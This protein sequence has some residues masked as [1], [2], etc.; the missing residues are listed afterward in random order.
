MCFFVDIGHNSYNFDDLVR[1]AVELVLD[2]GLK[3]PQRKKAGK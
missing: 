1:I 3:Y 2:L